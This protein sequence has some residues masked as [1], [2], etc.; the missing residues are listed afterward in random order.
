[1]KNVQVW[2]IT[3]PGGSRIDFVSGW[4]GCLPNFV[5]NWWSINPTTGQSVGHM[6]NTKT[7]DSDAN[8]TLEDC[9]GSFLTFDKNSNLIYV[10]SCHGFHLTKQLANLDFAQVFYINTRNAD[11]KLIAWES[12]V[13]THLSNTGLFDFDT[14][15]SQI[16]FIIK[17]ASLNQEFTP[18]YKD[19]IILDYNRLFTPGGSKYLCE[20]ANI[21]VLDKYHKFYDSNLEWSSS[22]LEIVARGKTWRYSDYF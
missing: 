2:L 11:P 14:E 19:S 1:M 15:I 13:K 21:K 18:Q 17:N 8:R 9:L 12:F 7:L 3:G 4:L 20:I 16:E 6:R 5:N 10:G 22:P